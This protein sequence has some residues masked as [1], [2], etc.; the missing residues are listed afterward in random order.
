MNFK[1][2]QICH[3]TSQLST[4]DPGFTPFDNTENKHPELREFHIFNRIMEEDH[5]ADVDAWGIVSPHCLDKLRY[6][7]QSI[8]DEINNNPNNDVWIFNHGRIHNAFLDNVWSQGEQFH[9][10][11]TTVINA[12][13]VAGKYDTNVI[14][15]LMTDNTCYSNYFVA[16]KEFWIEYIAFVKDIKEKLE[17]LTGNEAKLYHSNANYDTD[18]TLTLFVFIVERLFST[19]LH[20]NKKYKVH[21]KKYDYTVYPKNIEQCYNML[22]SL[23]ELKK[24]AVNSSEIYMH[25]H[26]LRQYIGS[27]VPNE[28]FW[29]D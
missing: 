27:T 14:N 15:E 28:L 29:L 7:S 16:K 23:Y 25:W 19:F 11:I 17:N 2:F 22:A 6:S 4:C 1:I 26:L 3:K 5:V 24:L 9:P 8:I 13:L 10:G 18:Q 12:A 20:L 21:T